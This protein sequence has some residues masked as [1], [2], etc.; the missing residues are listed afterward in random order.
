MELSGALSRRPGIRYGRQ[1]TF[2]I[3]VGWFRCFTKIWMIKNPNFETMMT[4][5]THFGFW[6]SQ[7]FLCKPVRCWGMPKCRIARSFQIC[8]LGLGKRARQLQFLVAD[9]APGAR[10]LPRGTQ[11]FA[12]TET[13][14]FFF[15]FKRHLYAKSSNSGKAKAAFLRFKPGLYTKLLNHRSHQMEGDAV[16]IPIPR[17][18]PIPSSHSGDF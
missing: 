18:S 11:R 2:R 8:G 4:Y 9:R 17:I 3:F 6:F 14:S 5:D 12:E 10:L 1:E 13:L 16:S 7:S 15:F